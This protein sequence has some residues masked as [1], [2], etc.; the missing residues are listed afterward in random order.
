MTNSN[1][2]IDKIGNKPGFIAA[3][4]QSD[5]STLKALANYGV[6]VDARE[7]D[8]EMFQQVHNMRIQTKESSQNKDSDSEFTI[9]SRFFCMSMPQW[10]S[11]LIWPITIMF[12]VGVIGIVVI[13]IT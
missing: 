3:I 7:Y 11:V 4:D 1:Q 12:V 9:E 8:A 6:T 2:Q 5:G 13:S 10:A